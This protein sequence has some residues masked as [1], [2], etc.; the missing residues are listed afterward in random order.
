M[1]VA[2][3]TGLLGSS[4]IPMF[5]IAFEGALRVYLMSAITNSRAYLMFNAFFW[6]VAPPTFASHFGMFMSFTLFF[7]RDT[8]LQ[9]LGPIVDITS[10]R[11]RAYNC[12]RLRAPQVFSGWGVRRPIRQGISG[13]GSD[14]S[15]EAQVRALNAERLVRIFE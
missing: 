9:E 14:L 10:V 13:H 2:I 15:L 11:A 7:F 1:F 5:D 3:V 6:F 12:H 4:W 8:S